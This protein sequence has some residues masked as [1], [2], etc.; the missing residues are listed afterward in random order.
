MRLR[1]VTRYLRLEI[2]VFKGGFLNLAKQIKSRRR[3]KSDGSVRFI[4][5][6]SLNA[7][8][9]ANKNGLFAVL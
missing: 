8:K 5:N 3:T 6:D 2:L 1:A 7:I 9:P 4:I